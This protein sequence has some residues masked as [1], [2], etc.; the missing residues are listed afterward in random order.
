[1]QSQSTRATPWS[2]GRIEGQVNFTPY[3]G[4][5]PPQK[6]LLRRLVVT[7][8]FF[9][10]AATIAFFSISPETVYG[11][12]GETLEQCT[13]R[14]G[15]PTPRATSDEATLVR[16][17]QGKDIQIQCYFDGV[18]NDAKCEAIHVSKG[19]GAILELSQVNKILDGNKGASRWEGPT[20]QQTP[21]GVQ[22]RWRTRDGKLVASSILGS[23]TIETVERQNREDAARQDKTKQEVG[24]F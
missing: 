18:G 2:C 9:V 11:R 23:L 14:Y 6:N 22:W 17:A 13:Q 24:N 16:F 5:T 7:R 3:E 21:L 20:K 10:A 8:V 1:M 15:A 19:F 4:I 12:V